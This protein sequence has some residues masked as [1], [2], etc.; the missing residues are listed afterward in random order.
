M[1][2]RLRYAA[3]LKR[4]PDSGSSRGSIGKTRKYNAQM[5]VKLIANFLSEKILP[6]SY[7]PNRFNIMIVIKKVSINDI[8]KAISC[9]FGMSGVQIS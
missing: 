6:I 7:D 9:D 1:M 5:P 3:K 8:S 2:K 4:Y